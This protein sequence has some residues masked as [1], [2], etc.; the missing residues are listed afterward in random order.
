M[1]LEGK[2]KASKVENCFRENRIS[3]V[4]ET[5]NVR[6]NLLKWA[7]AKSSDTNFN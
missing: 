7:A 3:S 6:L 2:L 4:P 1:A 5:I